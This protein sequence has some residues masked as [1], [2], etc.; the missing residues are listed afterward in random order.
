M[1]NINYK[2]LDAKLNLIKANVLFMLFRRAIL[3]V[4][5]TQY[6]DDTYQPF[7]DGCVCK[8]VTNIWKENL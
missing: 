8:K 7:S 6:I 4:N 2:L 3:S 1:K 5:L